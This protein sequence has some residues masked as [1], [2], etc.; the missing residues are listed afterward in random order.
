MDRQAIRGPCITYYV[1]TLGKREQFFK[2]TSTT[3]IVQPYQGGYACFK[4]ILWPLALASHTWPCLYHKLCDSTESDRVTRPVH[5]SQTRNSL[6]L[7]SFI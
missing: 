3:S 7:M 6:L 2:Q 1:V 4:P 5:L